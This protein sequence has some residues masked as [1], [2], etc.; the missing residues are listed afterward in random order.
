SGATRKRTDHTDGS[1][2]ELDV[3]ST[4]NMIVY[5]TMRSK[6]HGD[7]KITI[8]MDFNND[9]EYDVPYERVFTGYTS[10]GNFTIADNVVIPSSVITGLETGLRVILNNDLSPNVP[11]DEACG[12]YKSGETEDFIVKF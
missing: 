5:H 7:A 4:Y 8:F 11:S 12:A 10:V 9:K 2:I 3:D 6:E 1:V